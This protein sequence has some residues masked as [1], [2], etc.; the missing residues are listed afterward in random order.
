[1]AQTK[2]LIVTSTNIGGTKSYIRIGDLTG[3]ADVS[4]TGST[5]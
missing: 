5:I 4:I 3:P 1:M 2:D